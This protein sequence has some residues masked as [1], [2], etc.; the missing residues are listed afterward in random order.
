MRALIV[1]DSRLARNVLISVVF[2]AGITQ[3]DQATDGIE[4]VEMASR[5]NYDIIFMDWNMPNMKGI[6]AVKAIREL[7]KKTPIMMVTALADPA[8]INEALKAGVNN[9]LLKPFKPE[10]AA[11]KI[12]ETLALFSQTKK[13]EI[14]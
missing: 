9:Y 5:N 6:D 11:A 3:A 7:D 2:K 1:D 8:Q 13:A 10:K 4:A 12:E 14:A